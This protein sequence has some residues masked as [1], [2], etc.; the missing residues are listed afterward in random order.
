MSDHLTKT[1]DEVRN[2]LL[3]GLSD[4]DWEAYIHLV[5]WLRKTDVASRALRIGDAA[6]D[7]L[8]PDVHGRLRS[9]ERLRG[10]GPLVVSFYR[11]GWC[12]FCNAELRALQAVKAEFDSLKA[13]VV[14]LSPE[15]RDLPRL[16]KRQLNLDLTML[17]DVDHGVATSYGVLF[18]VPEET[19][20]HY[21]RLGYDFGHRHGSTEWMLPIPA[22]FVIDQAG[23]VRGAFVEPDFTIRQE[24]S[25]ILNNVRKL[26]GSDAKDASGKYLGQKVELPL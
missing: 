12:P 24:P 4:A 22:T 11:G 23:V 2:D 19:K 3:A 8:L 6:P 1:L 5:D 16:L 18:R 7:F 15:T 20:A 13:N 25:D 17:A 10:E 9:S 26:A 14:V 21:A